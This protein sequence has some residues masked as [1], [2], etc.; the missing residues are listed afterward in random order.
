MVLQPVTIKME[1]EVHHKFKLLAVAGKKTMGDVMMLLVEG[2]WARLDDLYQRTGTRPMGGM[3]LM[4]IDLL[5]SLDRKHISNDDFEK[6]ISGLSKISKSKSSTEIER[7]TNIQRQQFEQEHTEK[8][9]A[10]GH[11]L[12][13]QSGWSGDGED[14]R[15]KILK[16]KREHEEQQEQDKR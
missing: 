5:F 2:F 10:D 16:A 11:I 9:R 12:H 15:E 1:P 7:S 8:L 3:D 6:Q 4:L 14:P 13:G